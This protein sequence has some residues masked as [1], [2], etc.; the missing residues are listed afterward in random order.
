MY[1]FKTTGMK[2]K[3]GFLLIQPFQKNSIYIIRYKITFSNYLNTQ[4]EGYE[5]LIIYVSFILKDGVR[6]IVM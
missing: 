1:L 4:L 6:Y 2:K 3:K 5:E